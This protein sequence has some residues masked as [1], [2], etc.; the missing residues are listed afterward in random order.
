MKNNF[1]LNLAFLALFFE[2]GDLGKNVWD[3]F[4]FSVFFLSNQYH[5]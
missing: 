2:D 5:F 4:K 3:T 1:L